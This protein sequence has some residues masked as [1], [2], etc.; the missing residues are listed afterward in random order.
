MSSLRAAIRLPTPGPGVPGD[1]GWFGPRSEVWRVA[2]ERALLAAGPAALLLQVAHPLVAAGVAEHSDFRRDPFQRLRATLDATLTMAFGDRAQA[3]AAAARVRATHR[4]V[5]GRLPEPVGPF[6]AGTPYG[7]A[8]PDLAMWVHATLVWTAL[9]G[10]RRLVG[11]LDR[12][13]RARYAGEAARFATSLGVPDHVIPGTLDDFERY[14]DERVGRLVVGSQARALAV[15]ILGPPI[16][17][18]FRASLPAVRSF[19]AELLPGPVRAAYGLRLGPTERA[20]A[21]GLRRSARATVRLWPDRL[22]F[23]PHYRAAVRR[24]GG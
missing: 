7:A 12:N 3:G 9:E 13:R 11:P 16:P 21:A 10:S 18:P 14:W 5:R 23:W 6:P 20:L 22:R 17:F 19:T 24:M 8:D 1:P 2:R 15:D 4:R